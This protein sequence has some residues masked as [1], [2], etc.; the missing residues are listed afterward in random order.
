MPVVPRSP[1]HLDSILLTTIFFLIDVFALFSSFL[2]LPFGIFLTRLE[3]TSITHTRAPFWTLFT[4]PGP[5]LAYTAPLPANNANPTWTWQNC[6][7][8][9]LSVGIGDVTCELRWLSWFGISPHAIVRA[10][11]PSLHCQCS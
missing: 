7:S 11:R 3:K 4:Y 2:R 6:I 10:I 5:P 9:L 1:D 8:S